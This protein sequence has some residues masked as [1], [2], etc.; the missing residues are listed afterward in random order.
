MFE[1]STSLP[2]IPRG[3]VKYEIF[4]VKT[5]PWLDDDIVRDYDLQDESKLALN[6][7]KTEAVILMHKEDKFC[8]HL[9]YL[10]ICPEVIFIKKFSTACLTSLYSSNKTAISI[11]C[12]KTHLEGEFVKKILPNTIFLTKNIPEIATV[13]DHNLNHEDDIVLNRTN[14]IK[15]LHVNCS[16]E[17][18]SFRYTFYGADTLNSI[19]KMLLHPPSA[20]FN[21][22][23]VHWKNEDKNVTDLPPSVEKFKEDSEE[24]DNIHNIWLI[25]LSIAFICG[26]ILVIAFYCIFQQLKTRIMVNALNILK[27]IEKMKKKIEKSRP[28]FQKTFEVSIFTLE[29]LFYK[30]QSF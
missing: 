16:I 4:E 11:N 5:S 6:V 19:E 1:L 13:T 9:D 27:P 24:S 28:Y 17:S 22:A 2:L 21:V 18:S 3:Y 20:E 14:H 12:K 29:L 26:I 23:P 10:K 30:F 8:F 25:V 7:Q 15:L